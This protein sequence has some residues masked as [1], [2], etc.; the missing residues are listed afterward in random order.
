MSKLSEF[1]GKLMVSA[2]NGQRVGE[3]SWRR[4]QRKIG[5]DSLRR[6]VRCGINGCFPM[7]EKSVEM[8]GLEQHLA[9][10]V[11]QNQ[12]EM[13]VRS[14]EFTA[15]LEEFVKRKRIRMSRGIPLLVGTF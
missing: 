11:W 2:F 8:C 15:S 9:L 14:K 10:V 4:F 12:G 1:V 6:S 7:E 3:G 13:S 5:Q